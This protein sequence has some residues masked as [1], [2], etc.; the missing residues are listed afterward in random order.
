MP[1]DRVTVLVVDDDALLRQALAQLLEAAGYAVFTAASAH[2]AVELLAQEGRGVRLLL[3]DATIGGH[4][5]LVLARYTRCHWPH[6]RSVLMSGHPLTELVE[7]GTMLPETPF[8]AKPFVWDELDAQLR[9][10]L[11]SPAQSLRRSGAHRRPR[12][13]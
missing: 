4:D 5:G 1:R 12:A 6:I 2:E 10:A 11:A 9:A 3:A 13:G 7:R 8:L